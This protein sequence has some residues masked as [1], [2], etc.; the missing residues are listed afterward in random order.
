[1]EDKMYVFRVAEHFFEVMLP[2]SYEIKKLLPSFT[3]FY[4]EREEVN[5]DTKSIFRLEVLSSQ[6]ESDPSAVLLSAFPSELGNECNLYEC[7]QHYQVDVRYHPTGT[8]F[9]MKIS[10]D[11]EI[12]QVFID[13]QDLYNGHALSFFLMFAYAQRSV[14][15]GTFLLHASVVVKQGIGYAFMGKSGTGKST[16]TTQWLHHFSQVTL[17]NDDN[18]AVHICKQTKNV[19][20]SGTPWSGKTPCYKNQTVKLGALVRL[21]QHPV[22]KF[23]WLDDFEALLA[24]LPGCSSMRWNHTFYSELCNVLEEMVKHVPTG[25]LQCLPAESAAE[26]CYEQ[27]KIKTENEKN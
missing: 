27:I 13:R 7:D 10:R 26:L 17:L 19:F 3:P 20:I 12:S 1:M 9:R 5:V 18:P 22:N 24:V 8:L 23:K 16:H 2:Q 21:A 6:I 14:L 25:F 4:Q 11:F 15:F